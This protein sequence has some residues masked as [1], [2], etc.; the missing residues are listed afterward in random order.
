MDL[1]HFRRT[2]T[3]YLNADV[4]AGGHQ[5]QSGHQPLLKVQAGIPQLVAVCK[6]HCWDT[7]EI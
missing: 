5:T 6:Y 2:V 4:T 7:Y 1:A 3:S